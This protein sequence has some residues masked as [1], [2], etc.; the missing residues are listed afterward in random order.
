MPIAQKYGLKGDPLYLVDG[1]AYV[2]RSFYAFRDMS[3]SDGFPTN[4]LF[5]VLRMLMRILREEKPKYL[6]F[7][8]DGRGP[9]FRHELYPE[10]KAQRSATPEPLIQQ[11]E[12]VQAGV[13]AL[14]LTVDVSDGNEAD[15]HICSLA[16]RYKKERPVVIIA[17][18]K[19]LKQCLDDNVIMWDPMSRKE[20]VTTKQAF[21][22]ETGFA[23]ALWPEF[24]ALTGDSSDNIPGVPGV[25]PKTASTLFEQFPGL[26]KLTRGLDELKPNLR[27][28]IEPHL[29]DLSLYLKLTTLR[30]DLADNEDLERFSV[31]H[32]DQD[33]VAAFLKEYEFR[34]LLSELG[35][36]PL[37]NTGESH[38]TPV[39]PK[40]SPDQHSLLAPAAPEQLSLL[41]DSNRPEAKPV[42]T[43]GPSSDLSLFAGQE[44]GLAFRDATLVLGVGD[45]EYAYTGAH[46]PL[47]LA[48]G[49][50]AAL[51]CASLRDLLQADP[52][53]HELDLARIFDLG[54]AGYLL[55]PEERGY[56]LDRLLTRY[57]AELDSSP[58]NPGL[59]ALELGRVLALKLKNAGLD[60][61]MADLETPLIPVLQRMEERG[62]GIDLKAFDAF[63]SEVT[64]ELDRLTRKIYDAAEAPFNIRSSQQLAELLFT[65]LGL[66]PSGKTPGGAASTSSTVLQKLR[67]QHPVIDLVLE[68]RK[69][70]KMRSTYL[71]PLPRLV[72]DQGR[73][74]TTFNQLAT[75]T[76]RLSSSNPNL[77]NIPIRGEMGAR[78]RSCFRAGPGKLLV[79]ADYSQ[80][81]LRVLAHYSQDPTLIDAFRR[82]QD[83]HSRTAALLYDK[84]PDQVLVDERRNA[85]TVNFGL[86]YGM[87]P[88]KLAQELSVS[89]KEAKA[90][91]ERY[92]ERLQALKEFYTRVEEQAKTDGFVT[93]IAGRRRLLPDMLSRNQQ[94]QSQA[95]RQAINTLIQGSAADIIKLAMLAAE[96][97]PEL[98]SLDARLI[99][100]VHD[101]LLLET[102]EQNAPQA[103]ER[104]C[105][106]MTGVMELS[107]PLAVDYGTG[108]TW[109]EAH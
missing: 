89:L 59:A 37:P 29:E 67:G 22:E 101:E 86:I 54:L 83:I 90:F 65:T 97:S 98:D 44:T 34:T 31:A 72:D 16:A 63:L 8:L 5:N 70:E 50:C 66:K 13:A 88:Q 81:E 15:D 27:A 87:G 6:A 43:L 76:G 52:A 62:L 4:A 80:I 61:L 108:K 55:S 60:K 71:E 91:I 18:D 77:Q 105:A 45:K 25:G 46:Q 51:Y 78:M 82:N 19:D 38:Q 79:G 48:L 23:P 84:E 94:L 12:P 49:K 41:G 57:E 32:V 1:T 7:M 9:T 75:A 42:A 39:A 26:D 106:L 24:Q 56:A 58:D 3:R 102:P 2:Y 20:G 107:V 17:S 40:P 14:G 85:K 33:Q 103:A 11:L 53:W 47:A 74:H 99:L 96:H 35:R 100:Q 21:E 68:Y 109:A 95:R 28:K 64:G 73:V 10:Y 36:S 104:L 30:T 92:F 93:T 69:L